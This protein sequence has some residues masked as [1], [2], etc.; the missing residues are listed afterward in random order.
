MGAQELPKGLEERG[1]RVWGRRGGGRG[2][3]RGE[4]SVCCCSEGKERD[5]GRRR[6]RRRSVLGELFSVDWK[7]EEREEE[8]DERARERE[9]REL[10][11]VLVLVLVV[12]VRSPRGER[13]ERADRSCLSLPFFAELN[14]T[15]HNFSH[16]LP[17]YSVPLTSP[18][19]RH[20]RSARERGRKRRA[21]PQ[22][23]SPSSADSSSSSSSSP[24]SSEDCSGALGAGQPRRRRWSS[25]PPQSVHLL[26]TLASRIEMNGLSRHQKRG[27]ARRVSTSRVYE[28]KRASGKNCDSVR[29]SAW[30]R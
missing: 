13:R 1:E 14:P 25:R 24:S 19:S 30:R 9:R 10:V 7:E 29:S 8:E 23:Q 5:E 27:K 26:R 18:A 28:T 4:G 21:T 3:Q 6:R 15:F 20:R 16:L 22:R 17:H 12:V 2:G 11:L